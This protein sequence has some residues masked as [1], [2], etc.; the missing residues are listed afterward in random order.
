[1]LVCHFSK[2]A[3]K[4]ENTTFPL[5]GL[6]G[7][8]IL[9]DLEKKLKGEITFWRK[10]I[11]QYIEMNK[12]MQAGNQYLVGKVRFFVCAGERRCSVFAVRSSPAKSFL[13]KMLRTN[14]TSRPSRP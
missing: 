14:D 4:G 9:I 12:I 8:R 3:L 2:Q 11:S 5:P 10:D 1:M 13:K 7:T 6:A